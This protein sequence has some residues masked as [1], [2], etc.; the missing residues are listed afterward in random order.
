MPD[1]PS[2]LATIKQHGFKIEMTE[3]GSVIT[4]Y[5]KSPASQGFFHKYI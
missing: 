2:E 3:T 5:E 4:M 1:D